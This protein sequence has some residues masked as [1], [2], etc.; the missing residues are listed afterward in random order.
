[1]T[2]NLLTVKAFLDKVKSLGFWGRLF[3]W[4]A[5]R[6]DLVD[7][8]SAL[9]SLQNE[10]SSAQQN[11][12]SVQMQ[13]SVLQETKRNLETQFQ[14]LNKE[15]GAYKERA[16][17]C[18]RDLQA[19]REEN[20][21]LKK[22]DEFRAQKYSEEIV[23][24]QGIKQQLQEE[25]AKEVQQRYEEEVERLKS[26][27]ETWAAHQTDVQ[28]RMKQICQKH[29]LH[30]VDKAPFRGDPDNTLF[31]ADEYVVFDAKSPAGDDLKNFPL[32]L[33]AQAEGAKKYAKL[34]SV[35]KDIFLIVPTNTLHC[36]KDFVYNLADYD[37]YVVSADSLE[38]LILSLCKIEDYEF[39]EQ[40]SPEERENICR[41]IGKF[42][43][44]SKR[45]IQIDAFFARQ[46]IELAYKCENSLPADIHEKVL[47]F[48]RSEKLN[49]PQEKRAKAINTKELENENGKI[50]T[51]VAAKGVALPNNDIAVVLNEL[52]LYK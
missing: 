46:F 49:P 39:A 6:H 34:D 7:A 11:I 18:E 36:I 45:R 42:A 19:V 23:S 3:G 29:T 44:L 35:K 52:S 9:T 21:Q 1:M 4:T 5:V 51:E 26:L 13:F 24:L 50:E 27:K 40:L 48:E 38:P 17:N 12:A 31:I 22:E 8:A 33:K 16:Q 14:N 2:A 28:G 25:R 32:Y 47:E 37:V 43:H 41:I 10:L 15:L 20:I 30:Y